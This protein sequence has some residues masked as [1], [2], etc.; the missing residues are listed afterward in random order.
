MKIECPNCHQI[1]K[2]PLLHYDILNI[3]CK[4]C[5][6]F[7]LTFRKGLNIFLRII[8]LILVFAIV[9]SPNSLSISA[10]IILLICCYIFEKAL[11]II[12]YYIQKSAVTP[13]KKDDRTDLI[14]ENRD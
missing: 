7:L 5:C 10:F 11:I 12:L 1:N 14:K 9:V 6:T 3:S 13:S 2:V 8:S 4:Y